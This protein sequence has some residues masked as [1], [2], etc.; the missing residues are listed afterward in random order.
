MLIPAFV[1][2]R[3]QDPDHQATPYLLRIS[4]RLRS[5][6]GLVP[7][8]LHHHVEPHRN[9]SIR[10]MSCRR[11][12]GQR[13]SQWSTILQSGSKSVVSLANWFLSPWIIVIGNISLHAYIQAHLAVKASQP[14]V[15]QGAKIY[16]YKENTKKISFFL[17][18]WSDKCVN[19]FICGW[20]KREIGGIFVAMVDIVVAIRSNDDGCERMSDGDMTRW[21]MK[22]RYGDNRRTNIG[23]SVCV[24]MILF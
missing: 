2:E 20:K 13:L 8:F 11:L 14:R 18:G 17:C 23:P 24:F 21:S 12:L 15:L 1:F 7:I 3:D 10:V 4:P 9:S 19:L 16:Y 6:P 22:V 5:Q